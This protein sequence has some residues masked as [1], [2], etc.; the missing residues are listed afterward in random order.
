MA[1]DRPIG[2]KVKRPT[3][4]DCG[5]QTPKITPKPE[6]TVPLKR[7]RMDLSDQNCNGPFLTILNE[8]SRQLLETGNDPIPAT[9]SD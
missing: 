6:V 4:G 2:P 8:T 9:A 1:N 3:F 7:Q 5:R